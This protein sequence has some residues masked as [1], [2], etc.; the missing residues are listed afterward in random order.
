MSQLIQTHPTK[1]FRTLPDPGTLYGLR[2]SNFEGHV[3]Q[4][5][6]ARN[7]RISARHASTKP[8]LCSSAKDRISAM[9]SRPTM[10]SGG[11]P[12]EEAGKP[13]HHLRENTR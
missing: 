11:L 6:V 2:L 4:G 9:P 8:R 12:V 1:I 5:V 10:F 3:R 7:S 13:T